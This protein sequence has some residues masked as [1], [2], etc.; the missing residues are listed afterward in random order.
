[1]GKVIILRG[2]ESP[3][4]IIDLADTTDQLKEDIEM[5][6]KLLLK[7]HELP[8]RIIEEY[9]DDRLKLKALKEMLK[10]KFNIVII[11]DQLDNEKY[12]QYD[13]FRDSF[14]N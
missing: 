6:Y 7:N 12:I 2:R 1:M 5:N 8:E 4:W 14:I 11:T 13:I 3:H 10:I 9:Y